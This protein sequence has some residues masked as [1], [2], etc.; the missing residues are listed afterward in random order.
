M[1]KEGKKAREVNVE[2][3]HGYHRGYHE[4]NLVFS[5][6]RPIEADADYVLSDGTMMPMFGLEVE[7]QNWGI[8]DQTIYANVLKGIC[9]Q[10]FHKDL[11]KIEA[12]VSLAEN[13]DSSA[14]CITQPMTK[15]Y[16]RNHYRDFKAMFEWFGNLGVSCDRTGDC[17]MH[18]HISNVCFGR[19]KKTQ[20]EAIRKFVY[21]VNVH[22]ELMMRL[23]HRRK[24]A[25][26]STYYFSRMD[27][28]NIRN[29]DLNRFGNN[30]NVCIN[31]GHYSEGNIELRLVGGQRNFP[32]FRNTMESVF[33]IIE[34]SK[35]ISWADCDDVVKVFSGCN[36]YVFDRLATYVRD[37]GCI[38]AEQLEEIRPT[39]VRKEFI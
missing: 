5:S 22:Y 24:D 38:S 4:R 17:G 27:V 33:H 35:R 26:G 23:F 3:V 34:A 32:C 18:T 9:M 13:C 8:K 29:I 21:I 28:D 15:A 12:D 30:H 14:E 37:D 7:T 31:L 1:R 20:D 19:E 25:E 11:W 36:N 2:R 6:D 39:V 16:I 10:H